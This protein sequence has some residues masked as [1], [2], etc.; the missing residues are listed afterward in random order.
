MAQNELD[1][2]IHEESM[3]LEKN[4]KQSYEELVKLSRDKVSKLELEIKE[5]DPK[6]RELKALTDGARKK[7]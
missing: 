2:L 3:K 4:L 1:Q 7:F 5:E 6:R